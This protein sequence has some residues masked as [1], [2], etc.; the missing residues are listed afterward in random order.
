MRGSID[1]MR[2]GSVA[3]VERLYR[4]MDPRV[5]EDDDLEA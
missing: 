1:N 2:C 5:R 3:A 4:S